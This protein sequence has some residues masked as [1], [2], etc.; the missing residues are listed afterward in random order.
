MEK[1]HVAID[2]SGTEGKLPVSVEA[3]G[4]FTR[5]IAAA[6]LLAGGKAHTPA[7]AAKMVG[8]LELLCGPGEFRSA[9][10]RAFAGKQ[11]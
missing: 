9:E 11:L 6:V 4:Q 10:V 5:T 7:E 8:M 1:A 2:L 3:L